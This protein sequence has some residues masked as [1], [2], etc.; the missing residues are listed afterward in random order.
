MKFGRLV[1][2]AVIGIV[3]ILAFTYATYA[4]SYEGNYNLNVSFNVGL[5][6]SGVV[7]ITEFDYYSEPTGVM[8]FWSE[9]KGRG[10]P[11]VG[12][13]Q[14]FAEFNQSGDTETKMVPLT[15]TDIALTD[16]SEITEVSFWFLNKNAGEASVRIYVIFE[17]TNAMIYD[18]T[19]PVVIG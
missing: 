19:Y 6:E 3:A 12:I 17:H 4:M 2:V 11:V 13:Y 14:M 5:P 9:L 1:K 10:D 15:L 16:E 7:A 8:S 18:K